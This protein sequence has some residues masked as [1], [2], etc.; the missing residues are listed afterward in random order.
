LIKSRERYVEILLNDEDYEY[1]SGH[2]IDGRNLLPATG[3]LALVWQTI[4]M[5]KGIIY[6]TIPV[7]FKDINFI[8]AI[9]L[10]KNDA[11]Q[12]RIAI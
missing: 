3:Y 2:V 11:V 9:H 7:I 8:R 12:L 5:I 4:G 10:T 6:T 1:M